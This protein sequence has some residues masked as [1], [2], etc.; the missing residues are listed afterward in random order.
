MKIRTT[1][2]LEESLVETAKLEALA[3]KD[4]LTGLLES[5]LKKELGIKKENAGKLASY[6][7]GGYKFKRSD[8]YDSA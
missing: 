1:V 6:A 7:M 2:Y 5:G 8:A 4:S 3:R